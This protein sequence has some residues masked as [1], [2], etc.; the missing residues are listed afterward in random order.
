M[1]HT[2]GSLKHQITTS[3]TGML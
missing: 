3:R 2:L 1:K